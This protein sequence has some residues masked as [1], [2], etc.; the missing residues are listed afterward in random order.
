MNFHIDRYIAR[1]VVNLPHKKCRFSFPKAVLEDKANRK[2]RNALE[3]LYEEI[4]RFAKFGGELSKDAKKTLDQV[5]AKYPKVYE[6]TIRD[7]G[8]VTD[9]EL[10]LNQITQ[11][12][13]ILWCNCF[14]VYAVLFELFEFLL[15]GESKNAY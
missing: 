11:C 9:D 13:D 2:L 14:G 12:A 3:D 10:T 6:K 5:K 1:M 15:D 8:L 4:E 7:C